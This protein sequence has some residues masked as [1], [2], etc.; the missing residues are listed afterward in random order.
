MWN[1]VVISFRQ[2]KNKF[3]FTAE[4]K[5]KKKKCNENLFELP[6]AAYSKS[7]KHATN[8]NHEEN[9][10]QCTFDFNMPRQIIDSGD[11]F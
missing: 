4:V 2:E 5:G 7:T 9:S 1:T 8:I 11:L 6:K 10:V 3:N